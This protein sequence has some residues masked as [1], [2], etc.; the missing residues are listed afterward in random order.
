MPNRFAR[1]A[2]AMLVLPAAL[3]GQAAP[4]RAPV[5]ENA[6]RAQAARTNV[7]P[8]IDG[9]LDEA[10]WSSAVPVSAFTQVDPNEGQP[11]SER[12]E[13]RIL[14]DDDALYVGARLY[15]RSP[16][17]TRLGRRDM[18][19][20]DA[21]WFAAIFDSYHDHQTAYVFLV[22]P[23]GVL[24]DVVRTEESADPS[25]DAVWEAATHVDDEGWIAELRIPFSQLRFARSDQQVWGVQFEREITRRGETAHF[26]FTP[27]AEPSGIPRY[28]HLEGLQGITTGKRLEV[29]PY[30]VA[31][32]ERIEPG[33]N[34]FRRDSEGA[35][36]SGV[37]LKYRVSS[38]LT[39]NASFNPDFG[40]VEVDPAVVN[41]SAFETFFQE[42]RPF[43]LEGAAIFNFGQGAVGPGSVYR[44]LFYSRRVG[45]R[46]QLGTPSP[47]SDVPDASTILGAAKLS[48]R[49]G[50][51]WSV[52]VLEAL[53]QE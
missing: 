7:P 42:K 25:W 48:G 6:P 49:L 41:L 30:I 13:V 4:P 10:A 32:N 39:L 33:A 11:V 51:G 31:R 18:E 27:K 17:T 8:R 16:V 35:V 34:P 5:H 21:D 20:G 53:T 36:S 38:N 9:R 15:D 28:G 23:S 37:D 46:P 45:R 52:G 2:L 3:A 44:N 43:F 40:Q 1:L 22:N 12:T 24:R 26:S 29:L 47:L 50:S 19:R 14:Y